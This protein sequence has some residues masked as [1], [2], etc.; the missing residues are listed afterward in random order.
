M[1]KELIYFRLEL[2]QAMHFIL[3]L[4]CVVN[5]LPA[6]FI[7]NLVAFEL[8]FNQL[9]TV[10][11][12]GIQL[13]KELEHNVPLVE[14]GPAEELEVGALCVDLAN[15]FLSQIHG[16]FEGL[17]QT[18]DFVLLLSDGLLELVFLLVQLV[19]E[20]LDAEQLLLHQEV[21]FLG[22][23]LDDFLVRD[24][25]HVFYFVVVFLLVFL[26]ETLY[27]LVEALVFLEVEVLQLGVFLLQVLLNHVYF[28]LELVVLLFQLN[29]GL[30][31]Q[32][33][34]LDHL[35]LLLHQVDLLHCELVVQVLLQV[36]QFLLL[37]QKRLELL[38]D[39]PKLVYFPVYCRHLLVVVAP[40]FFVFSE[41]L[42][43]NP[44]YFLVEGVGLFDPL[45]LNPLDFSLLLGNHL[46]FVQELG[47]DL[48]FVLKELEP[49]VVQV[50]Q[51]C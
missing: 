35:C 21:F 9:E 4:L 26:V 25:K 8:D 38:L 50:P 12:V 28:S 17:L 20:E 2:A 24:E 3:Q 27:Y 31:L 6:L 49:D 7:G 39:L 23:L 48:L 30:L 43:Q 10:P 37:L 19:L 40:R 15:L 45:Q 44:G 29:E 47:V 22:H 18:G 32:E 46:L 13:L 51:P 34:L 33:L 1:E 5:A 16:V 41:V 42:L 11:E 36:H 14:Q